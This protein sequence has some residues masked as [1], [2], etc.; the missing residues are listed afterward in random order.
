MGCCEDDNK[1]ADCK[2]VEDRETPCC[3]LLVGTGGFIGGCILTL[4]V[5]SSVLA[6]GSDPNRVL[7]GVDFEGN[8][9]ENLAAWPSLIM[10]ENYTQMNIMICVDSCNETLSNPLMITPY[11]STEY[12]YYCVPGDMSLLLDMLPNMTEMVNAEQN[13]S[14]TFTM[15]GQTISFSFSSSLSD[16]LSDVFTAWGIIL[17]SLFIALFVAFGYTKCVGIL[18]SSVIC[19]V[20]VGTLVGGAASA[21]F[22]YSSAEQSCAGLGF[23]LLTMPPGCDNSTV[24]NTTSSSPTEAPTSTTYLG[25]PSVS[26]SLDGFTS[27][28]NQLIGCYVVAA[29]T[30]LWGIILLALR[31]K[32]EMAIKIVVA[33]GDALND[34]GM[35]SMMSFALIPFFTVLLYFVYWVFVVLNIASVQLNS[36]AELPVEFTTMTFLSNQWGNAPVPVTNFTELVWDDSQQGNFAYMFFHFLWVNQFCL[37]L[38]Y[39]V[40]A[41]AVAKWYF[42]PI[43]AATG[44]KAPEGGMMRGSF[45]RA[46]RYNF[47][48][49]AIGSFILAVIQFLRACMAYI[50][51][52][53]KVAKENP[54]AD[55]LL[56]IA[57]CCLW[58]LECCVN[59]LNKNA[60]CWIAAWGGGFCSASCSAVTLYL[61]PVNL[62]RALAMTFVSSTLLTFGKIF[63]ALITTLIACAI[64]TYCYTSLSSILFPAVLIFLL[65]M[66]VA[67]IFISVYDVA[68]DVI[69]MCFCVDMGTHNNTLKYG[70]ASL[71][72][73]FGNMEK[74]YKELEGEPAAAEEATK[75][76]V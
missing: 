39:L 16:S 36:T 58:C 25:I 44:K 50:Q 19:I 52:K 13:F 76:S 23:G 64:M 18:G 6:A 54:L 41:G 29:L 20:C 48:S 61:K 47:G 12:L 28:T 33:A 57:Q 5:L 17:A 43:D 3:D 24:V 74:G 35:L 4:V 31:K 32:I 8:V 9:C 49:I 30:I 66:S 67:E 63:V 55:C 42:L 71:A 68:I 26:S 38:N 21:Y 10:D 46:C 70:T 72:D 22:L 62:V 59:K 56:K 65:A 45:W 53:C 40:I 7:K 69:F 2:F 15:G 60:Y 11:P 75:T 73:S 51:K 1:E 14:T 27:A 34:I 37:Y